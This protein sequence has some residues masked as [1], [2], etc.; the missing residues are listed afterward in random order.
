[1]VFNPCPDG[2]RL[3]GGVCVPTSNDALMKWKSRQRKG[4][5]PST[6][7]DTPDTPVTPNTPTDPDDVD[8]VDPDFWD[9]LN[10]AIAKD[11]QEENVEQDVGVGAVTAGGISVA[12]S[13]TKKAQRAMRQG[14]KQ[15]I[16]E[17]TEDDLAE[18]IEM[19]EY[20]PDNLFEDVVEEEE[21]GEEDAFLG[22]QTGTEMTGLRQRTAGGGATEESTLLEGETDEMILGEELA[23]EEVFLTT[24]E[25]VTLGGGVGLIVGGLYLG[26]DAVDPDFGKVQPLQTKEE[27]EMSGRDNVEQAQDSM[28]AIG[29]IFGN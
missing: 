5:T 15:K 2:W 10:D 23:E 27:A 21:L 9:N 25:L 1:M 26:A 11:K 18:E 22:G 8:P 24:E 3:V 16:D 14:N 12:Y 7:D 4:K 28:N 13:T 29:N 20:R 17:Y 19:N 6:P